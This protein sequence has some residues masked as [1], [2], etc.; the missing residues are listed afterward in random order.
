MKWVRVKVRAFIG[1]HLVEPG[2]IVPVADDFAAAPHIENVAAPVHA[3][4]AP[5]LEHRVASLSAR[6]AGLEQEAARHRDDLKAI[7]KTL[8]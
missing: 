3:P 1:G 5:T 4:P 2:R 7:L 8:A 6:I